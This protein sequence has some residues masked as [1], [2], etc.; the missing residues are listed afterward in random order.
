MGNVDICD[1]CGEQYYYPSYKP[2]MRTQKQLRYGKYFA[3]PIKLDLLDPVCPFCG[4]SV[5]PSIDKQTKRT[6]E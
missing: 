3:V 5:N 6:G 4:A 2:R 1:S